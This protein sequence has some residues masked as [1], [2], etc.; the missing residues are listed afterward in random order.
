MHQTVFEFGQLQMMLVSWLSG[1]YS[2]FQY[3]LQLV[4]LGF[5]LGI[6]Q[7]KSY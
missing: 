3:L 2:S 7:N 1:F 4:W 5:A 6:V